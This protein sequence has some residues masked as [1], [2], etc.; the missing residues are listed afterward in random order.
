MNSYTDEPIR[1]QMIDL[2]DKFVFEKIITDS[3]CYWKRVFILRRSQESEIPWSLKSLWIDCFKMFMTSDHECLKITALP[4]NSDLFWDIIFARYIL[5]KPDVYKS[6]QYIAKFILNSISNIG[7]SV[8]TGYDNFPVEIQLWIHDLASGK[9]DQ[10][11][12]FKN[13]LKTVCSLRLYMFLQPFMTKINEDGTMAVS[14][15]KEKELA[16]EIK[17]LILSTIDEVTKYFPNNFFIEK[18]KEELLK[19]YQ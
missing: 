4:Y 16:E 7:I 1:T 2:I 11:Q 18:E 14:E 3:D 9:I 8:D 6:H 12:T 10:L 17:K 19:F 15:E 5:E 13:P